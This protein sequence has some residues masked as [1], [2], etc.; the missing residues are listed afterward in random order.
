MGDM[1]FN[2]AKAKSGGYMDQ[3]GVGNARLIAVLVKAAAIEAD[4]TLKRQDTL[5]AILAGTTDECDFTNYERKTISVVSSTVDDVNDW[6][7]ADTADLTWLSA[8]GATNNDVGAII[9]CFDGDITGG[10]DA[11]LIPL[12][13]M[14]YTE[15]TT[16]SDLE[17]RVNSSGLFRSV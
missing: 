10:S 15:T 14:D 12:Y 3:V 7:M 2:I 16:G 1:Q 8:G 17:V 13:K 6:Y 4:A 5:A 11:N 9:F